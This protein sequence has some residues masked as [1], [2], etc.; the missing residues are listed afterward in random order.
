LLIL[1][2]YLGDGRFHLE[3]M[4]IANP[5]LA[6]AFY[7][8][9]PYSAKITREYYQHQSM[10]QL[11]R[12]AIEAV[13]SPATKRRGLVMGTLGRQGSLEVIRCIEEKANAR[14]KELVVVL[15]SELSSPKLR[16][17][18]DSIDA[19]IQTSCPRLSI[20]WGYAYDRP[21]LT[22]YEATLALLSDQDWDRQRPK[23]ID[24]TLST[25]CNSNS[26]SDSA[27]CC[28]S[29]IA[30][31]TCTKDDSDAYPMDF[32]AF[33]SLGPWTPNHRSPSLAAAKSNRSTGS[34]WRDKIKK[35]TK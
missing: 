13:R 16:H 12:Q 19:W 34:S 11:R 6:H 25:S 15:M 14:G 23:W 29:K 7:R 20:D 35:A 22:P 21:L 10:R 31:E 8:Y 17:F 33:D 18:V 3:S 1:C 26:C 32:Y 9:D 4:M 27:T 2:R 24:S 30:H 28:S 5:H